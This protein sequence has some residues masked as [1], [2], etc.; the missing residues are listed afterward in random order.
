MAVAGVAVGDG[1]GRR[2]RDRGRAGAVGGERA[3]RRV[4]RLSGGVRVQVAQRQGVGHLRGRQP[5]G[6]AAAPGLRHAAARPVRQPAVPAGQGRVR[7]RGPAQPAEAVPVPV[8]DQGAGPVRVPQAQ[9]PGGA[10]PE[11]QQHTGG[12]VRGARVRAG[13]ARAAAQ[14]QPHHEGAQRRVRARAPAGPAGRVRVP[15]RA[16]RVHRVRRAGTVAR[17]AA[18]GP[19][20]AAR[21]QAVHAGVAGQAA[22]RAAQR[23]PVELLVQAAAAPRVDGPAERAVRRAARVQVAGPAGAHAVGQTGAGR[24]RVRAALGAGQAGG[25]GHGGRQRDRVVPHVRRADP[26]VPVDAQR[27]AGGGPGRR[28][29]QRGHRGPV[30]EP[31][32]RRGGRAGRRQLRVRAGEPVRQ[33]AVQRHR[34]RGQAVAGAG[35]RGRPVRAARAHRGRHTRPV[36]V[37]HIPVRAGH[38]HQ[39]QP[40]RVRGGPRGRRRRWRRRVGRVRPVRPVRE[41]RNGPRRRRQGGRCRGGGGGGRAAAATPRPVVRQ[42]RPGRAAGLRRVGGHDRGGRRSVPATRRRRR[43]RRTPRRRRLGP[44]RVAL[45]VRRAAVVDRAL[46]HGPADRSSQPRDDYGAA[47]VIATLR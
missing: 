9:E 31:D 21:R 34:G 41:D 13:A 18:A 5:D 44:R 22:R 32:H 27:P 30:H 29:P 1:G 2:P 19:Q 12:A 38:P 25:D 33:L 4:G 35:A 47:Q 28:R 16:A 36:A 17:V 24:L 39:G 8:P 23:Q 20:S 45:L 37:P 26:V 6:G 14:R 15:R 42:E 11:L 10:G 40:D 7:G 46:R 3:V 43:W